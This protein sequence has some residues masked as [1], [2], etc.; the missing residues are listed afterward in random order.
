M[1]RIKRRSITVRIAVFIILAILP[2]NLLVIM[3]TYQ[4]IG[5]LVDQ[6]QITL[7]SAMRQYMQ[8]LDQRIFAINYYFYN[9]DTADLDFIRISQGEN[10]SRYMLSQTNLAK[11]FNSH[12]QSTGNAD[13]FFYYQSKADDFQ[14]I[15]PSP[16]LI[17]DDISDADVRSV[18]Q[19]YL[20]DSGLQDA[21]K[22]HII[23]TEAGDYLIQTYQFRGFYYGALISLDALYEM[24]NGA[25]TYDRQRIWAC[26]S[27]EEA[28]VPNGILHAQ[29][30]SQR[31]K[32]ALHVTVPRS[33]VIQTL[34]LLQWVAIA[35]S[36]LYLA[37]IPGMFAFL[38]KHLLRPLNK[39]KDALMT[40]KAGQQDYR[41]SKH[42]YADEF[43]IINQSFNEMADNIQNLKIENYEK[44]I[45][46]QRMEL[47]NLQLQIRPHFLLNMFNLVYSL[48][49]IEEYESIQKMSLYLSQ[50]FRYIFRSGREMETFR[51]EFELIRQYLEVS[52]IRYPDG[53][54]VHYDVDPAMDTLLV[55]PLLLHNFVENIINYALRD[56]R[57]IRISISAHIEDGIASVV[58]EDTGTGMNEETVQSI[59]N[60]TFSTMRKEGVHIGIQN[61]YQR[62][63][64]FY[65]NQSSI[66]VRSGLGEGTSFLILFPCVWE[67]SS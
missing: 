59:N 2:L 48:A 44:D 42:N 9:L 37:L 12:I 21:M 66:T 29:A 64:H 11:K 19:A 1:N 52:G 45:A 58:I 6:A 51:Q 39:I 62:M 22:W 47:K 38:N 61:S 10:D 63:Q 26:D 13:A 23:K 33:V 3:S 20:M 56:D 35:L 55:P 57:A 49:E 28:T 7:N 14:L 27:Q 30:L 4:S 8:V 18:I 31:A 46:T 32:L 40:L 36:L 41:I 25:L 50:Y 16:Y 60:R 43:Q 24:V 53:F 5:A 15:M 65:G 17:N 34:P 54:E 67:A